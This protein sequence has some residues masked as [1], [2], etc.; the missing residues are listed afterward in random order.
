M[1]KTK[2][3]GIFSLAV[4][5]I[6]L[7]ADFLLNNKKGLSATN[8]ATA[9]ISYGVANGI[10]PNRNFV[11]MFSLSVQKP[12]EDSGAYGL[13]NDRS[14]I[15]EFLT[16]V[17]ERCS[18]V[19]S[20]KYYVLLIIFLFKF[21]GVQA[22]LND[23]SIQDNTAYPVMVGESVPE[24]FYTKKH[25]FYVDGT[26]VTKSFEEYKGKMIILDFWASWC[27]MCLS[28]MGKAEKLSQ[29]YGDKVAFVLVNAKHRRDDLSKIK[30][31]YGETLSQIG[32]STLP[33]VYNDEYL[34]HL[35]PHASIPRYVWV[36]PRGIVLAITGHSFVNSEQIDEVINML[37]GQGNYE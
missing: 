34:F 21:E 16:S 1:E 28:Q 29:K 5:K 31:T 36:S 12:R 3:V 30:K 6:R 18:P 19:N 22:Q 13:K 24:D 9:T 11:S 17:L 7:L 33:T 8:Q 14:Q 2:T 25:L 37:R 35:F 20:I 15:K 32:G 27:G 26:T 10:F 4:L 23:K